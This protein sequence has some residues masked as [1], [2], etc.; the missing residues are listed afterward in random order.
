MTITLE[1]IEAK[2]TELADL[3]AKFKAQPQQ[4]SRRLDLPATTIELQSG[5]DYA[6]LVLRDDGTPSHHLVLLPGDVDDMKWADAKAWAEQAAGGELPTR[7]EQALLYANCKGKFEHAWYWSA[8][9]Y[10]GDGSSA[11]GQYFDDGYPGLTRKG[12][13]GRARAVRRF[14]A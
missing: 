8:E 12:Y 4:A 6:G 9:E 5:E 3:I 13:E 10:E 14:A 7:Q 2:Q 11:W 1:H